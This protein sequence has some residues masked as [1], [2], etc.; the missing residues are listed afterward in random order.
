MA[1]ERI[2]EYAEPDQDQSST[3]HSA[4]SGVSDDR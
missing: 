1:E 3:D 2:L 4:E